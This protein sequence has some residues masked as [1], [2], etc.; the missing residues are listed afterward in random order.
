MHQKENV[1]YHPSYVYKYPLTQVPVI[2][3]KSLDCTETLRFFH[4]A[5][6]RQRP[7][8]SSASEVLCLGKYGFW[9]I[10]VKKISI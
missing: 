2:C 5:P 7:P 6:D 1:L 8:E 3:S 4:T 10:G 9:G